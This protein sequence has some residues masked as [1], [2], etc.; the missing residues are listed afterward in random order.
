M[1]SQFDGLFIRQDILGQNKINR[2]EGISMI[3]LL[4]CYRQFHLAYNLLDKI[5]ISADEKIKV[6]ELAE[7]I[8]SSYS[9]IAKL[10]KAAQVGYHPLFNWLKTS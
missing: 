6:F 10:S 5:K 1:L 8:F 9:E 2:N 3:Y 7:N 4:L